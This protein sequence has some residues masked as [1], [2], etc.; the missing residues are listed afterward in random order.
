MLQEQGYY[1]GATQIWLPR[2]N[3]ER[4]PSKQ[5]ENF[6]KAKAQKNASSSRKQI[7]SQKTLNMQWRV[8]NTEPKVEAILAANEKKM[9]PPI[10]AKP[11]LTREQKGKWVPNASTILATTTKEVEVICSS[12]QESVEAQVI[13]Q[14]PISEIFALIQA[15][16]MGISAIFQ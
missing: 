14:Q 4:K 5:K 12:S 15:K 6:S 11:R 9:P 3:Q 1:E 2:K 7:G 8:K 10:Q 13:N 16:F